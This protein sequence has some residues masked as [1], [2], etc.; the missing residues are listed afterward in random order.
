[1]TTLAAEFCIAIGGEFVQGHGLEG[2][3]PLSAILT[4][5][6]HI[7]QKPNLALAAHTVVVSP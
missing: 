3:V 2:L 4:P 6:W 1:M 7:A 5:F